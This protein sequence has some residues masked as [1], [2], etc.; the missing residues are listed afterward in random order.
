MDRAAD[1][2]FDAGAEYAEQSTGYIFLEAALHGDPL[3]QARIWSEQI[4]YDTDNVPLLFREILE[5]E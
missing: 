3:E 2:G 1:Y 5:A 4:E